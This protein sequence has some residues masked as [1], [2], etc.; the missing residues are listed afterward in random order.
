[1][2]LTVIGAGFPRTGTA[3]LKAA[4]EELGIGR[5]Y[6]MSEVFDKPDHWTL[7]TDAADGKPVDWD[8][9]FDGFGATTDAPA[10]LFYDGIAKHF[11][12]AKVVLSVRDPERW[13]ESTQ[14][15]IL[16]GVIAEK[17]AQLPPPLAA[18]M[19]KI[20]WHP[21]DAENHDR[22]RMIRRMTDH[23]AKVKQT[24]EPGRLLTFEAAQGW[25][26]L[27]AFLGLPVPGTPFP[28]INSTEE[29][30]K[31]LAGVSSIDS[32]NPRKALEDQAAAARN[33]R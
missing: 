14:S 22:D 1:M 13:F 11:P 27:C 20:G 24:I 17:F 15:T 5:C 16:S 33:R 28:H 21:A 29:F 4:F 6:H 26:P 31:M 7:W 8:R 9:L 3:S 12:D 25:E 30:K 23:N 18:M 2:S 19:H 32:A 10:C